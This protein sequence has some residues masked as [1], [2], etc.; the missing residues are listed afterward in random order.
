[1]T[2]NGF[3]ARSRLE[4][5]WVHSKSNKPAPKNN[6]ERYSHAESL[7]IHTYGNLTG[8]YNSISKFLK[9]LALDNSLKS[10]NSLTDSVMALLFILT[11]PF[12]QVYTGN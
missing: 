1:M 4:V 9:P 11:Y 7:T 5:V 2:S 10:F 6:Y 3:H 8:N 12:N